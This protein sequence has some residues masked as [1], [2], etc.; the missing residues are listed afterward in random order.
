M[1]INNDDNTKV[2]W[3]EDYYTA[4][5][6]LQ[7][8]GSSMKDFENIQDA[9]KAVEHLVEK[10]HAANSYDKETHPPQLDKGFPA[11][12][13]WWYVQSKGKLHE[14]KQNTQKVL[15]QQV[16][17][18]S[19]AQLEGAKVF[20]EGIGFSESSSVT[21]ENAKMIELKDL[22]KKMKKT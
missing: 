9:L 15:S 10:N 6:I 20:M 7:M 11:F 18:K 1:T 8:N 12:S 17:L 22:V 4:G 21:I 5:S 13:K 16:P 19:L 2:A 3:K 14:N